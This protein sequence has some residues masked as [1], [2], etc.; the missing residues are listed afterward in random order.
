M[1]YRLCR[2]CKLSRRRDCIRFSKDFINYADSDLDEFANNV[3]TCLANNPAFPT[4]SVKATDLAALDATF[5][6]AIA[7]ATGDPQD[8]AAKDKARQALADALRKDAN[9]VETLASHDLQTLLS[10]G[11]Y[12]NSTNHAQ[13][14]L[15]PPVIVDIE[16][17]GHDEIAAAADA[18]AQRE[19]LSGADQHKRQ[20]GVG[21]SGHFHAGAPHG[22]GEPDAGHDL[23]RAGAG[24][25]R[26]HR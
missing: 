24:D 11:Y 6:D 13:T 26:Q 20:R 22:A 3:A 12:A 25:W 17:L 8:T 18:G 4:P 2:L 5:R 23:Q 9:Y 21:G 16:N 10:S 19:V 15:D 14:P 7:A 1:E